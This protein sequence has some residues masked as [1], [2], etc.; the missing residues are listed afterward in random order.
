MVFRMTIEELEPGKRVVWRC[1]G[2]NPEWIGTVLTWDIVPD[3]TATVPRFSRNGWKSMSEMYAMC[4]STWG[5]LMYR[6]KD[7]LEGRNPG[8][9]WHE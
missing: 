5:E 1:H 8:P 9:H 6:M 4:N 7:F 3:G 2:D